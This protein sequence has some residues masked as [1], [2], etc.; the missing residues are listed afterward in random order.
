M[1]KRSRIFD[2][3][4]GPIPWR[5]ADE[6]QDWIRRREAGQQD[7]EP[8]RWIRR[9]AAPK[10]TANRHGLLWCVIQAAIEAAAR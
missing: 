6:V 8:G 10:S 9:P 3:L 7:P 1:A 2:L 4:S 5:T